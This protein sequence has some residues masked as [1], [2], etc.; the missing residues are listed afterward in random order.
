MSEYQNILE[1]HQNAERIW[2]YDK[3]SRALSKKG[4]K[5]K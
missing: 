1:Q 3:H 5:Q 4:E 2:K